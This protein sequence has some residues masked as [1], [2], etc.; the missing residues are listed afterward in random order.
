MEEA[1]VLGTVVAT[2]AVESMR[3]KKLLWIEPFDETG[4]PSGRRVVAADVTQ[5]GPGCRVIFVRSREAAA[6]F[7]DPFCPIDACV[8]GIV[9]RSRRGNVDS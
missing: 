4:R 1:R 9:D 6:A 7:E 3:G 8:V 2:S 5:A